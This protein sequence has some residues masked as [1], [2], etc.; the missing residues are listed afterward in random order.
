MQR[1]A[2][3]GHDDPPPPVQDASDHRPLPGDRLVGT[4]EVG[5]AEVGGLRM[6]LE[7]RGLGPHHAITL[8]VNL[9]VVHEVGILSD[10]HRHAGWL[11]L[12]RVR[13]TPVGRHATDGHKSVAGPLGEPGDHAEA[14]VHG[15]DHVP[16]GVPQPLTERDLV[17]GIGVD[18]GHVRRCLRPLV[19]APMEDRHVVAVGGEPP[20]GGDSARAR[21]ADH[22][23]PHRYPTYA[24]RAPAAVDLGGRFGRRPLGRSGIGHPLLGIRPALGS[25]RLT[26]ANCPTGANSPDS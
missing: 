9:R 18:V 8:V 19:V 14:A 16:P 3:V 21:A 5:V 4:V 12:P 13:P 17:V 6:G 20:H 15:N 11:I 1:E 10:R 26:W 2:L 22:Q 25:V 23:D 24:V 7:H